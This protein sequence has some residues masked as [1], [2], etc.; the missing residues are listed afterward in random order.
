MSETSSSA[1]RAARFSTLA[2]QMLQSRFLGD[3][4][5]TVLAQ[6]TLIAVGSMLLAVSAQVKIPLYPVP[7]TG[8]TLVV[9][10]IGMAYGPWLGGA[11]VM[12]YLLEGVMGMPVFAGG[13]AG[14][15]TIAGPTGGY[16]IG[17]AVAAFAMG[18]LAERGMGRS[19]LNT[20]LAM[21]VGTAIIYA[22][23][24][25]WLNNFVPGGIVDAAK[26]G[27]VPFLFGDTLKLIVAAGLMPLAWK[28][29]QKLTGK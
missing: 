15:L 27:M 24:V 5:L 25:I 28:A 19:V 21:F 26:V 10:L 11:T 22:F 12:A 6:L 4:G 29:V 7:V 2:N 14:W 16:L 18:F 1:V 9:L 8:Q 3:R 20:A 23:G 17:F 13:A